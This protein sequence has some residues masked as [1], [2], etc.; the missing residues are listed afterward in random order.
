MWGALVLWHFAHLCTANMGIIF[1][2]W[3]TPAL[4]PSLSSVQRRRIFETNHLHSS[5]W[6][7]VDVLCKRDN[8]TII[9]NII[10]S[11]ISGKTSK[12]GD[13]TPGILAWRAQKWR[14]AK[15]SASASGCK[16]SQPSRSHWAPTGPG[17]D[18]VIPFP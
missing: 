16:W 5:P 8:S 1:G 4:W 10:I 9:F 6:F 12:S 15:H 17:A 13:L 3:A 2:I 14:S 11:F 18:E 7:W